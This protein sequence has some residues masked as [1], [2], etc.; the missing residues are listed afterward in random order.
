MDCTLARGG[1]GEKYRTYSQFASELCCVEVGYV[2]AAWDGLDTAVM[3][4]E[5]Q[6]T[7]LSRKPAAR[8]DASNAYNATL[9]EM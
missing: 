5:D 9:V 7:S 1:G 4:K 6:T 8:K 3:K 2:G